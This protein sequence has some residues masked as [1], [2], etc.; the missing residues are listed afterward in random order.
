LSTRTLAVAVLATATV[1]AACVGDRREEAF[2]LPAGTET[3]TPEPTPTATPAV[4]IVTET[5][6]PTL[7]STPTPTPSPPA[8]ATPAPTQTAT[9]A[10][11]STPPP[12]PE[13]PPSPSLEPIEGFPFGSGDVVD[14]LSEH[15]IPFESRDAGPACAESGTVGVQYA[16]T[17]VDPSL[18]R[19]TLW[20]YD[21]LRTVDVEW[22]INAGEQLL[23]LPNDACGAG[24][25]FAYGHA[26]LVLFF[27]R[28]PWAGHDA[29]RGD[30]VDAALS[31]VIPEVGDEPGFPFT[32]D[33]IRVS[34]VQ[35]GFTLT[36]SAETFTD[37]CP[38]ASVTGVYYASRPAGGGDARY[39]VLW[40]YPDP[41]AQ[42]AN[43]VFQSGRLQPLT[44]GCDTRTGWVYWNENMVLAYAP[45]IG[46]GG[47]LPKSEW[48]LR[49]IARDDAVID[50]FLRLVR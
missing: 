50:S 22:R 43:W 42:R 44:A 41:E 46:S 8:P 7:T 13:P 48:R 16:T 23:L 6:V 10:P 26:N 19:F 30:I 45:W 4:Q 29:L 32:A 14:L 12:T 1:L 5:P 24:D 34:V 20:V 31:L 37:V 15:G 27:E 28:E 40:T 38:N 35:R 47:E 18:P 11:T 3:Q 9:P 36:R 49:S 39:F 2:T 17:G 33:A 25:G 21:D